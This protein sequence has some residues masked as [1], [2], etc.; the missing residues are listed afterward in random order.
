MIYRQCSRSEVQTVFNE[1]EY[2]ERAQSGEFTEHVRWTGKK[3]RRKGDLAGTVSQ[4][5]EYRDHRGRVVALIHQNVYRHTGRVKGR[6]D[7][8]TLLHRG[9]LYDASREH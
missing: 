3:P 1:Q 7:P 9:V 5:V 6:P 2:W 4:T 8:I